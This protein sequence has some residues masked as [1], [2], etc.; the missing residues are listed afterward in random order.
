M[1]VLL[2][3]IDDSVHHFITGGYRCNCGGPDEEDF[4]GR[5]GQNREG[6]VDMMN[7][8][9]SEVQIRHSSDGA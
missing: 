2:P 3:L 9:M 6:N 8:G 1:K 5:G 4:E 7:Q